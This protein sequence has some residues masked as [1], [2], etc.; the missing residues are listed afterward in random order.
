MDCMDGDCNPWRRNRDVF[1]IRVPD[2]RELLEEIWNIDDLLGN[3]YGDAVVKEYSVIVGGYPVYDNFEQISERKPFIDVIKGEED[4]SVIIEMPGVEKE[5]IDIITSE[6]Y[7]E[8]KAERGDRRYSERIKLDCGVV[9]ETAKARYNNG[10]L[11]IVLRRKEPEQ[12]KSLKKV[13]V[14]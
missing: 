2:F 14:E 9:P 6:N 5:D 4:V 7:V 10:V 13:K 3:P 11:E 1:D 12:D 8:V